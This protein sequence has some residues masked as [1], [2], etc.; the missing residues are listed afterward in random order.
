MER[1]DLKFYQNK[2]EK[3]RCAQD[4]AENAHEMIL[5]MHQ[6]LEPIAEREK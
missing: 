1:D 6:V 3:I 2:K 5:Q 4:C